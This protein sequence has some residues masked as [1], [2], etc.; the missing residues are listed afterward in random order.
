MIF[1]TKAEFIAEYFN[2]PRLSQSNAKALEQGP[3]AYLAATDP[4]K[5]LYYEEPKDYFILGSAV[6]TFLT[7]GQEAF[8]RG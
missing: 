2:N 4:E 8:E 6:D 1:V 7:Q 5:K 3:G